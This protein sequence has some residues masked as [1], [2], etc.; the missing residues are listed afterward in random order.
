M[1]NEYIRVGFTNDF[2][3]R[4]NTTLIVKSL[5]IKAHP[6]ELFLAICPDCKKQWFITR[7]SFECPECKDL[8]EMYPAKRS[9]FTCV[10]CHESWKGYAYDDL[11]IECRK[12]KRGY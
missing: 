1:G 7:S 8:T 2:D 4:P 5:K 10:L 3:L 11:C 6:R 12:K 9:N